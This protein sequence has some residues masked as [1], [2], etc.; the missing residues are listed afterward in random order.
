MVG[1]D[2]NRFSRGGRAFHLKKRNN[3][4]EPLKLLQERDGPNEVA[5]PIH[6]KT[7]Q[8][9]ARDF[10]DVHLWIGCGPRGGRG[11]TRDQLSLSIRMSLS[12]IFVY[13]L[14]ITFGGL[15]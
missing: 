1:Q 13:N 7:P 6:P 11:S 3:P 9:I 14:P 10:A 4:L 8:T 2:W 12:F 5:C 15:A